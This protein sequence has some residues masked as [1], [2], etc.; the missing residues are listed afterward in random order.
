M[1]IKAGI[2]AIAGCALSFNVLAGTMGSV[3]EASRPW[4][5]IGTLGV[6]WYNNFYNGGPGADPSAQ[7]AIGDG[8]TA[9]GRF[10]IAKEMGTFKAVHLGAEIGVQSGNTARLG[11]SQAAIDNVGGLLPQVTIKPLLDLLATA[12]WQPFDSVP[13][14]G[15][16]KPGIA[17]R[18]LQVNDRVSFNDLSQI[19]FEIQA[20][21]GV[22]VSERANLSLNYQGIFNGNTTY[23]INN[24]TFTGNISNIPT[25]DGI[26]LSLSYIV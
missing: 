1:R 3:V 6:T 7:S 20:G 10:A 14:Y 24:T 23:T 19:A 5:V 22:N 2:I 11:I 17:Y 16:V 4:S 9:L 18:R 15:L 21:L 8:Q 12:S 13:V 25:Q 26:L